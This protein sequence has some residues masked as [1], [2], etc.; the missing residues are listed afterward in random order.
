MTNQEPR[1]QLLLTGS[2]IMSGDTVDSNS[3][4]IAQRL[5]ELAIGVYRKVTVGD[6]LD[7]LQAEL[8]AMTRDASLVIVNGGLGPVE[9]SEGGQAEPGAQGGHEGEEGHES[10][11]HPSLDEKK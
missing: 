2:E 6:D 7:L 9:S 8:S 4:M 10:G 11:G 5:G 3:A 1:V